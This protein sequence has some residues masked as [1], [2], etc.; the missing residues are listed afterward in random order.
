MRKGN[1]G[2]RKKISY[3]RTWPAHARIFFGL[4]RLRSNAIFRIQSQTLSLKTMHWPGL[5]LQRGK[6]K[7]QAERMGGCFV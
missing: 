1:K 4:R 5:I 3:P 7:H 2:I 6:T